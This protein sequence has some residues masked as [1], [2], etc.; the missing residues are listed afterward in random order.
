MFQIGFGKDKISPETRSV[1]LYD[2]LQSGLVFELSK[3]PAVSGVKSYTEL[4]LAARNEEK[5]LAELRKQQ[6]Y[7]RGQQKYSEQRYP[8][9]QPQDKPN[10]KFVTI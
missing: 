7:R 8:V 3:T 9:R 6:Q 1:L 4:Y 2:Q 5:R 10:Q